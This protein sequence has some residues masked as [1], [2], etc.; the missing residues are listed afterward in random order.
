MEG[1]P[2]AVAL[3]EQSVFLARERKFRAVAAGKLKCH[4][5][6]R[7]V[8]HVVKAVLVMVMVRGDLRAARAHRRGDVQPGRGVVFAV[9]LCRTDERGDDRAEYQ[10]EH[11]EAMLWG[12]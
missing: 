1:Q 9:L 5:I 12:V 4:E 2:A 10:A 11:D 6:R 7:A 3:A 8:V